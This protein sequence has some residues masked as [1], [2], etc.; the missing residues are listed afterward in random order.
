MGLDMY[1]RTNSKTIS[2]KVNEVEEDAPSYQAGW[3][4][5]LAKSGTAC[6]WRKANQ[7]HKW[8]VDHVQD[9]KD[10]CGCYDV[11]VEQLQQLLGIVNK[12]LDSTTLVNGKVVNGYT[13]DYKMNVTPNIVDGMVLKDD[14]VAK[15]LLP[16]QEGFF[17]GSCDYDEYY[18]DDLKYTKE[19]LE[20]ILGMLEKSEYNWW[21]VKGEDD[22][23]VTFQYHSSW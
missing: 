1:L 14:S 21:C 12:V 7:I 15:K 19:R 11:E 20:Q 17:F 5:Y 9:G 22:W 23:Y 10:D 8:F 16:T 18:W 4:E 6:V 2:K 3:S 13:F